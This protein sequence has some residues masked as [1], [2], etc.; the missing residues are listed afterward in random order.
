MNTFPSDGQVKKWWP[1][2]E[3]CELMI[4]LRICLKFTHESKDVNT[5][6][7]PAIGGQGSKMT[8]HS[9]MQSHSAILSLFSS[10]SSSVVYLLRYPRQALIEREQVIEGNAPRFTD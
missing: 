9:T 10:R 7:L 2:G 8:E 4:N 1:Y 6:K 3:A 5:R